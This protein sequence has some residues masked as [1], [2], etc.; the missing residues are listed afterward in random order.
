VIATASQRPLELFVLGT[1]QAV[2]PSAVR[3]RLHLEL[4]EVYATLAHLLTERGVLDEALPLSTCARLEL[5]ALAPDADRA[6]RLLVRMLARRTGLPVSEVRT[7]G[8]A[9]RGERAVRHLFRVAAVLDSVVH[10]E[11][12]IL[13]QVREAAELPLSTVG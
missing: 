3:E 5:Y 12:E 10:G 11:A 7:H 13:V 4:E 9:L 1:S 8:Y 6:Q 2:A